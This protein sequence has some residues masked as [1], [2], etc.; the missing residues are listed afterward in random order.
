MSQLQASVR[1]VQKM[2]FV[3]TA[4]SNHGIVLDAAAEHGGSGTGTKPMELLLVA[5]AGCS[6]MDLASLFAKMRVEHNGFEMNVTAERA[7]EHPM[8]L[9]AV[10]IEYV[11]YGPNVDEAKVRRAV[12][13][14]QDKYCGVSA[15]LRKS[16]PVNY[17]IRIVPA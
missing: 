11:V 15:M 1:W 10:N 14:S 5:V 16:C 7:E 12:E 6:G 13:L 9:T 17:T 8:V 3:G 2:Q 4:G